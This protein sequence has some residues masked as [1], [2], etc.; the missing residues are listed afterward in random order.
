MRNKRSMTN[1]QWLMVLGLS[2][3]IYHLPF[4]HV[5]AQSSIRDLFKAMPD[6]MI[7]YL[8][9]NNRLDFIDFKDSNMD[10]KV[11]NALNG[12]STMDVL[13]D[14]FL[15]LTLNEASSMQMRLLPVNTPVDSMQQIICIV[16]SIGVQSKHSIVS[17]YSCSW[18]P[19]EL[20]IQGCYDEA[21]LLVRPESMSLDRFNEIRKIFIPT[22]LY[23]E[24]SPDE[25]CMTITLSEHKASADDLVDIETVKKSIKLKWNGENF[26][27]Y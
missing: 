7:P 1:V 24:L 19:L 11:S 20:S 3:F 23:A 15:S 12:T 10:A 17:F 9:Q 21:D 6:S 5:M 2:F 8:S 25:D 16:R 26:N 18:R 22:M 27:K 13:N 4:S 14:R